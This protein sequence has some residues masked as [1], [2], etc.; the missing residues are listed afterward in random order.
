MTNFSFGPTGFSGSG[1]FTAPNNAGTHTDFRLMRYRLFNKNGSGTTESSYTFHVINDFGLSTQG[2]MV[3][4]HCHNW[5]NDRSLGIISWTN[6]GTGAPLHVVALDKIY[7][8]GHTA[9]IA[10]GA[11]DHEITL[12]FTG[13]HTNGHGHQLFMWG[14]R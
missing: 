7:E 1:D 14:G 13:T 11:N 4:Y 6:N 12:S 5:V 9:S 3:I 2:G 10:T 8:S